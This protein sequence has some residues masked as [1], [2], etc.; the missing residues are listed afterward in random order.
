M[1]PQNEET[2]SH[3]ENL[4]ILQKAL[5][6]IFRIAIWVRETEKRRRKADPTHGRNSTAM[7]DN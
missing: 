6:R 5:S 2:R 3:R 7:N 4:N 1:S